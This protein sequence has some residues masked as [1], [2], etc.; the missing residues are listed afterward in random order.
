MDLNAILP[1]LLGSNKTD[2]SD[3]I[4]AILGQNGDYGSLFQNLSNKRKNKA[5]GFAPLLGF[6]SDDI[7]GIMTRFFA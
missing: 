5:V 7:L 3:L 4:K 1:L 6:V 2:K